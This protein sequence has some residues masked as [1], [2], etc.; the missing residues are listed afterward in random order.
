GARREQECGRELLHDEV[1]HRLL[2]ADRAA[3]VAVRHPSQPA[4]VL[5]PERLIQAELGAERLAGGT[6]GVLAEH[7]IDRI[8]GNEVDDREHDQRHEEEHRDDAEEATAE[9][10]G[11]A[12]HARPPPCRPSSSGVGPSLPKITVRLTAT[13]A[14]PNP[15]A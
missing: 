10:G 6:L 8:T 7:G 4:H 12:A 15:M 14:P 11:D 2:R 1:S 5:A 13:R 3:E 9:I